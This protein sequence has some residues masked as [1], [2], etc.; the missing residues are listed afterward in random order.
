[1][2]AAR[3]PLSGATRAK[4]PKAPSTW[5]QA[6]CSSQRS[7]I[8]AMG[9][10]SPA[11]TSPALAMTRAGARR[12]GPAAR[13]PG[14]ARS[15][16]PRSSRPP[17]VPP[18]L[19]RAPAWPGPSWRSGCTWPLDQIGIGGRA[20]SRPARRGPTSTPCCS[21]HHDRA[22]ARA[23]KLAVVAPVVRMPPHEAEGRRGRAATAWPSTSSCPPSGDDTHENE[24]WSTAEASQSAASAAGVTPPVTKW[25]KRGP[26]EAWAPSR[27]ATRRAIAASADAVLGQRTGEGA[28]GGVGRGRAHR[29]VGQRAEITER[30]FHRGAQEVLGGVGVPQRVGH[31]REPIDGPRCPRRGRARGPAPPLPP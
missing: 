23:V 15:S 16:V 28:G 24:F 21:A 8:A 12:R 10:N 29:P 11:L 31:P 1:M 27:P 14:P 7:A 6:P 3:A 26:A 20:G 25:K 19:A 2:P 17:A 22:A 4:N 18:G 5:S 13:P 30:L 9:S